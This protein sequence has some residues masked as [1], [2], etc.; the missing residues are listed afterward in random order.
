[1]SQDHEKPLMQMSVAERKQAF[2][3]IAS[4]LNQKLLAA[5]RNGDAEDIHFAV[6]L[7]RTED[8]EGTEDRTIVTYRPEYGDRDGIE[9]Q[10]EFVAECEAA[11]LLLPGENLRVE[12]WTVD[13]AFCE[14]LYDTTGTW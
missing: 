12:L 4:D 8:E 1:M 13:A 2:V 11:G 14:P 3:R 6:T 9:S 10:L 5:A 7:L